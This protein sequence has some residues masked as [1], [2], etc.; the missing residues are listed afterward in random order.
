MKLMVADHQ[1]SF[2]IKILQQDLLANILCI[3]RPLFV[4]EAV[5]F[6]EINHRAVFV[7]G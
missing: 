1:K 4:C 3:P 7:S 6:Y 2:I 5:I